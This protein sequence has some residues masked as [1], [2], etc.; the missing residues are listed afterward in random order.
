M[1]NNTEKDSIAK[2]K[3]VINP[4]DKDG[5]YRRKAS[6]FRDWVSADQEAKFPAERE[7]YVL[8]L[9]LG[10]PWWV[11]LRCNVIL[12]TRKRLTLK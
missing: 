5:H 3:V 4:I 12:Q 10:C 11:A 9:N 6:Q 1:A 2:T 8:Y 7:R